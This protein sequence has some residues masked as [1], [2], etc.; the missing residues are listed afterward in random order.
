MAAY[1]RWERRQVVCPE[2]N[3]QASLLIQWDDSGATP[4]VSGVRCSHPR[5]RDLDNWECQWS[6]WQEIAEQ[7]ALPIGTE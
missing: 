3:C 5:L 1:Y 6:C 2:E 4:A 7:G